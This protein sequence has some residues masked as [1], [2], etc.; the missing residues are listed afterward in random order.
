MMQASPGLDVILVNKSPKS[1]LFI[2][3]R[4]QNG[5]WHFTYIVAFDILYLHIYCQIKSSNP[6]RHDDGKAEAKINSASGIAFF[7]I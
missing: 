6:F 2:L 3:P 5:K 4:I 7:T 1:Y